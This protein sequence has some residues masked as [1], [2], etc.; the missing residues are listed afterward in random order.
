VPA[1]ESIAPLTERQNGALFV[2][3]GGAVVVTSG[4]GSTNTVRAGAASCGLASLYTGTVWAMTAD[5]AA[6][7]AGGTSGVLAILRGGGAPKT[8]TTDVPYGPIVAGSTDLYVAASGPTYV[9]SIE[10]VPKGGGMA[11]WIYTPPN[12]NVIEELGTVG[13]TLYWIEERNATSPEPIPQYVVTMTPGTGSAATIGTFT[14]DGNTNSLVGF[15]ASGGSV[16]AWVMGNSAYQS[17]AAANGVYASGAGASASTRID[18]LGTAPMVVDSGNAYYAGPK[19]LQRASLSTGVVST[20]VSAP[21]A[22]GGLQAIAIG[23]DG[24]YYAS[25]HCIYRTAK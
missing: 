5:A 20:L 9:P 14:M 22:D 1:S 11:S 23:P 10:R 18:P 4:P 19:G 7:Y 25:Q 2:D 24:L 12:Q 13:A 17:G 15:G 6:V 3:A 8:L 16:A 21:I